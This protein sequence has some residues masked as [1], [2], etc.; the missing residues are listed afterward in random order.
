M[1]AAEDI[2]GEIE[3]KLGDK[4]EDF[5]DLKSDAGS[6]LEDLLDVESTE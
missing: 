6:A 2:A 1:D 4:A 3:D 5:A